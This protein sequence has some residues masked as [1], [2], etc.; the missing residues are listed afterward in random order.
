MRISGRPT[1]TSISRMVEQAETP[2]FKAQFIDWKGVG[3]RI[4]PVEV[5]TPKT[6]EKRSATPAKKVPPLV[7]LS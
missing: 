3:E 5:G 1:Y 6:E 4:T 7:N 2:P